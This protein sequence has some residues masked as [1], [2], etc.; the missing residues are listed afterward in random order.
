LPPTRKPGRTRDDHRED[1]PDDGGAVLC[2]T[3]AVAVSADLDHEGLTVTDNT[4]ASQSGELGPET[5]GDKIDPTEVPVAS[6]G[7]VRVTVE[8]DDTREPETMA[9]LV[10][11]HRDYLEAKED[12][13][14]VLREEDSGD[15]MVM[16]HVHRWKTQYR[17]KTY[18]KLSA[19]EDYAHEKW[20][21]VVPSTFLTCTAPHK[22]G[23]GYRPYLDVLLEMK[24][25]YN[26]LRKIIHK[27]TDGIDTEVVAVWE[28]HKTGYPHLHIAV[29]G[30]ASPSLGDR[31]SEI[32]TEKYIEDASKDAQDCEVRN[33]RSAQLGS[34]LAYLMKYLGKTL[35]RS[36]T[37]GAGESDI[38]ARTPTVRGFEAFSALL[39]ASERRQWSVT[40]GLSEAIEAAAPESDSDTGSWEF[41][42][43]FAGLD[44]G[45]YE[46]SDADRMMKFL[47]GSRNVQ[48]PPS[49]PGGPQQVGLPPD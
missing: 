22:E 41:V 7:P 42:G 26:S 25:A 23:G 15:V 19:V 33:G 34:P 47:N 8:E 43:A 17:R 35:T 30:L 14:L 32:W 13:T 44:I 2:G 46:G 12:A 10:E 38:E 6:D 29:L 11:C 40:G 39:W 21:E 20:G 18:A 27:E 36:D 37:A 4:S 5:L 48:R 49:K 45:L 3:E 24:E 16:P 31:V 28:P 9:E 1:R